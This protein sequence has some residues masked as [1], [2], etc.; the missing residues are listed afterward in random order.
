MSTPPQL[1]R[2][3]TR[4]STPVG[5]F[6]SVHLSTPPWFNLLPE[7]RDIFESYPDPKLWVRDWQGSNA[8][9]LMTT[10]ERLK[11]LI[12]GMTGERA[13]LSTPQQ[14]KEII[15]K[16]R[17]DRHKP[18]YHFLISGIS[19]RAYNIMIA[20]PIIS[21][22]GTSA[23]FLP[24]NPP[25]P[26]F[27]CSIE[28]FTLS[29][30]TPEAVIESEDTAME[31]VRKTLVENELT[32]AFIKSKLTNDITSQHNHDPA[33][34]LIRTLKVKLG[35]GEESVDRSLT[36]KPRKP[37]WNL[38]F[39]QSPP[40]SWTSYF[41]LLQHIRE[42][43]FIDMD[44]GSATLVDKRFRLHCS[45]CKGADHNPTQ[46]AFTTVEGWY[47]NKEANK[48]EETAEFVSVSRGE[49]H[50]NFD[51]NRNERRAD[52]WRGN[53]RG[54]HFGADRRDRR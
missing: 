5:G 4:T 41:L 51:K 20:H 31:I 37:V 13:K 52:N 28:G 25:T 47:G 48:A 22:P 42:I 38:F 43:R 15:S 50:R 9:D 26:S 1:P 3:L 6:P 34:E 27:L 21:T 30:K 12:R 18:P 46:C 49:K 39:R 44:Y 7:Q 11:E 32:V 10:S 40:L 36:S 16:R 45:N 53:G 19:E 2:N 17:F 8:A 23:F 54:T 29:I 24:Y 33:T 14:E 35:A